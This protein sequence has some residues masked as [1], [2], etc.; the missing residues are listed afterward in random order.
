M[1][2]KALV[3]DWWAECDLCKARFKNHAGSS[4]C[5][6]SIMTVVEESATPEEQEKA[7]KEL[8]EFLGANA[9]REAPAPESK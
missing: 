8:A 4:P 9:R 1:N 3:E 2:I 7:D 5:C 6:G